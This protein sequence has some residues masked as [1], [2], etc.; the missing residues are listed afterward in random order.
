VGALKQGLSVQ[1]GRSVAQQLEALMMVSTQTPAWWAG[2]LPATPVHT[3]ADNPQCWSPQAE[4]GEVK[5]R[6]LLPSY[7]P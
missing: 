4:Q 1:L 3:A 5:S 2:A 7:L 6:P